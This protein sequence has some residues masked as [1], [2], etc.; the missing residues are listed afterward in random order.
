M[1]TFLD[2]IKEQ[3]A[4]LLRLNDEYYAKP[5]VWLD[6]IERLL[7]DKAF[8]SVI[9]SGMG[10]SLFAG[11]YAAMFLR[12][13]GVKATAM[14]SYEL[15]SHGGVLLDE[16]KLLVAISQSGESEELVDLVQSGV[17][18]GKLVVVT[19]YD[20]ST[21]SNYGDV[22]LLIHAGKELTTATKSYTNT[23]AAVIGLAA[24]L[25]GKYTELTPVFNENINKLA[26]V[27]DDFIYKRSDEIESIGNM[28]MNAKWVPLVASGASYVTASHAELVLEEAAK[29]Y[30]SRFTL[31]QFIHGPIETIDENLCA[32]VFD[33]NPAMRDRVDRVLSACSRFNG[34]AVLFTNRSDDFSAL[35][36]GVTAVKIEIDDPYFAVI[37]EI[38]P[39][40]L[41]VNYAGFKKGLTPGIL[42]RVRKIV[43]A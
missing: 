8:D 14:E 43:G 39:I 3:S 32:I 9:F 20:Q 33:F 7:R 24:A 1:K 38:V 26:S 42:T 6:G 5:P 13:H 22:K 15:Q 18:K 30:C 17:H 28:L 27:I 2:E 29:I 10:S 19:N 4:A 23:L 11:H 12:E 37:A 31:G 25:C 16:K 35:Y 21:L 40:E 34:S 41:S 36:N